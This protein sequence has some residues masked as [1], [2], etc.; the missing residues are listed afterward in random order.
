[1]A[2]PFAWTPNQNGFQ[3]SGDGA[4]SGRYPGA[5][6]ELGGGGLQLAV[7]DNVVPGSRP[8]LSLS[9]RGPSQFLPLA[10]NQKG[11]PHE[12]SSSNHKKI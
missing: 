9:R 1:M 7:L 6:L 3:H 5:A 2:T 4:V 11:G 8:P 10:P 12:G